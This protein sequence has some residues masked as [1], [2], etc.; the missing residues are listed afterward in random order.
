[1]NIRKYLLIQI[2]LII[3]CSNIYA[4]ETPDQFIDAF[5]ETYQTGATDKAFDDLFATNTFISKEDVNT[6]KD[7]VNQYKE[8]IG[9]YHGFGLLIQK[10]IGEFIQIN[11]YML[12]YDRQPLRFILTFYKPDADWK[13]YNFRLSDDF[14]EELENATVK[15][16]YEEKP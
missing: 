7:K 14:V 9:E 1:M 11:S 2:L 16:S 12:K 6:I 5:F 13:I 8:V 10:K 4:Q 15:L 3:F